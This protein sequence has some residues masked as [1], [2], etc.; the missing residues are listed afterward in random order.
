LLV[1]VYD[2]DVLRQPKLLDSHISLWT[3]ELTR[4]TLMNAL[5]EDGKCLVIAG[6]PYPCAFLREDNTCDIYPT[7]PN[8]CVGMQAGSEQCQ[9]SRR[10]EEM[11][12]L[13]PINPVDEPCTSRSR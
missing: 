3:R 13:E 4:E 6:S 8:V 11:A 10:A 9:E 12:P 2:L 5:E 1:E 7:R